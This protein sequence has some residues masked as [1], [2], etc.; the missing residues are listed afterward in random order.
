MGTMALA[1][2]GKTPQTH[3][4]INL[5]Y[6]LCF[7]TLYYKMSVL[8]NLF[9]Y[10]KGH[11]KVVIFVWRFYSMLATLIFGMLYLNECAERGKSCYFVI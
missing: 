6:A 3:F 9:I 7:P 1:R 8:Y 4:F 5:S 11:D 2:S 10:S